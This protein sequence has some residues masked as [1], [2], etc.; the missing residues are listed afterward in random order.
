VFGTPKT[1]TGVDGSTAVK[2]NT[3][4]PPA[5]EDEFIERPSTTLPIAPIPVS[6]ALEGNTT[7]ERL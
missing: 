1:L 5:Q 7:F 3:Y 4:L 6:D 2:A